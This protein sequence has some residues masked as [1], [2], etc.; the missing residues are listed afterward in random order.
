[1]TLAAMEV[2]MVTED[3]VITVVTEDLVVLVVTLAPPRQ[4]PAAETRKHYA[5]KKIQQEQQV[6][7]SL[8]VMYSVVQKTNFVFNF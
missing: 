1:M 5:L 2:T 6:D 4:Q 8:C 7:L 3:L